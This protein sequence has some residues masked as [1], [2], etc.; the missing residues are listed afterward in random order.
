LWT[1]I[2]YLYWW[3]NIINTNIKHSNVFWF[4]INFNLSKLILC[5]TLWC[6]LS[7]AKI[8]KIVKNAFS[9]CNLNFL[10]RVNCWM[11]SWKPIRVNVHNNLNLPWMY[12]EINSCTCF[13]WIKLRN[14]KFGICTIVFNHLPSMV[15]NMN[16]SLVTVKP[17]RK[18]IFELFISSNKH[19]KFM[20]KTI[21]T[22]FSSKQGIEDTCCGLE[23]Y[24]DSHVI[25]IK[26]AFEFRF[27]AKFFHP[28]IQVLLQKVLMHFYMWW[29]DFQHDCGQ[30]CLI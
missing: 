7:L 16:S 19:Y 30:S 29:F 22:N 15:Y 20:W 18:L 11:F 3:Q 23:C 6:T 5:F 1:Y 25:F 12:I 28:H 14:A 24:E 21:G 17:W 4:E 10:Y 8:A 26:T 9:P 13:G 27:Y 2:N